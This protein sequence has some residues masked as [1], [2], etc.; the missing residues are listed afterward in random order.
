MPDMP[1][2]PSQRLM[3]ADS[4]SL[5]LAGATVN[6]AYLCAQ[7][8]SEPHVSQQTC[9]YS[10]TLMDIAL[11]CCDDGIS[12]CGIHDVCQD[13]SDFNPTAQYGWE[14]SSHSKTP[15]DS[16]PAS[17]RKDDGVSSDGGAWYGC[18]CSASSKEE[19]ETKYPGDVAYP[20]GPPCPTCPCFQ[21][22]DS[23]MLTAPTTTNH[24]C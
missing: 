6:R 4:S 3:H 21:V 18:Y 2:L 8:A 11:R 9:P 1:M 14:C 22:N 19:C 20:K 10:Y 5:D 17:C 15:L 24:A 7:M 23:C 12:K 13:P 16:C